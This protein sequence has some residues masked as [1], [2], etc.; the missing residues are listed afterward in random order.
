MFVE[1]HL[2]SIAEK[3]GVGTGYSVM[4]FPWVSLTLRVTPRL[5]VCLRLHAVSTPLVDVDT[6]ESGLSTLYG[7]SYSEG[8]TDLKKQDSLFSQH[9]GRPQSNLRRRIETA[10]EILSHVERLLFDIFIFFVRVM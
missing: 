8:S 10:R 3:T 6:T 9:L 2:V 7:T 1:D 5:I 4:K